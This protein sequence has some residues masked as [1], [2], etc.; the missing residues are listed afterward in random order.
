M[1]DEGAKGTLADQKA[2]EQK[3]LERLVSLVHNILDCCIFRFRRGDSVVQE[4]PLRVYPRSVRTNVQRVEGENLKALSVS[5][6]WAVASFLQARTD[7]GFRFG[8]SFDAYGSRF[9]KSL[10]LLDEHHEIVGFKNHLAEQLMGLNLD[11]FTCSDT[12]FMIPTQNG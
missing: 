5:V 12:T 4:N 2:Y 6:E 9:P 1:T 10:G 7:K 11:W 3:E 8:L